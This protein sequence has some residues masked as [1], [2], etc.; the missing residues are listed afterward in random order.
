MA[1]SNLSID[2]STDQLNESSNN[3]SSRMSTTNQSSRTKASVV[4][5]TKKTPTTV[6]CTKAELQGNIHFGE[7]CIVH[8]GA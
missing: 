5:G 4:Q 8:P 6:I 7:G 2:A 1:D 3:T